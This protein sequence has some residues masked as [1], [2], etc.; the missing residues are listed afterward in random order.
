MFD[1]DK[2]DCQYINR[3]QD[4]FLTDIGKQNRCPKLGVKGNDKR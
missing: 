1:C 2:E 4:C 3:F